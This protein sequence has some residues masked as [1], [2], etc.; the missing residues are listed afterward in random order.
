MNRSLQV[1]RKVLARVTEPSFSI[2]PSI[3]AGEYSRKLQLGRYR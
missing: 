1:L 2:V 3:K